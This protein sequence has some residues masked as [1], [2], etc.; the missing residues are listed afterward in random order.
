[1][2][3]KQREKK[4]K[5]LICYFV[6]SKENLKLA[7]EVSQQYREGHITNIN[8]V[9]LINNLTGRGTGQQ[10]AKAKINELITKE[11][12]RQ[13]HREH[14]I[15]LDVSLRETA[16]NGKVKDIAIKPKSIG[17]KAASDFKNIIVKSFNQA[18]DKVGKKQ[19]V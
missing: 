2:V 7:K 10:K 8:N 16:L 14:H 3:N 12:E 4:A 18:L 17:I 15:E 1:M 5:D 13:H 6:G 9:E 19:N 11:K